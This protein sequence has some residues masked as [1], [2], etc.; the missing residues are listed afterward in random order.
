MCF[1][2][3]HGMGKSGRSMFRRRVLEVR[4][5]QKSVFMKFR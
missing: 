2:D 4:H 3:R 5:A 1:R